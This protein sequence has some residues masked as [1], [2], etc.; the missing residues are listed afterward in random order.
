MYIYRY[1]YIYIYIYICIYIYIY[2]YLIWNDNVKLISS[3]GW[4]GQMQ[5]KMYFY[6]GGA[7]DF[8]KRI[9]YILELGQ[10]NI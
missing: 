5:W 8:A 6:K 7:T 3:G 1:I 10:Y 4:N 9:I 2:I